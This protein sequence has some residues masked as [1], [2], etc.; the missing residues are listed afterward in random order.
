MNKHE[1]SKRV[2]DLLIIKQDDGSYHLFGQYQISKDTHE[3]YTVQ[4]LNDP[5]LTIKFGQLKYAVTWCV[6]HKNNKYKD[7]NKI[8]ELDET[9]D[10]LSMIID[11][12]KRLAERNLENRPIH[13]A[14]L[15]Q[16]KLR[17]KQA[18]KAMDYYVEYSKYWQNKTFKEYTSH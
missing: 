16:D 7:L 18:Q 6:F 9:L 14:K 2:K 12:H 17:R 10:S 11:N 15:S 8:A 3:L 13:L 1:L 5:T 4:W